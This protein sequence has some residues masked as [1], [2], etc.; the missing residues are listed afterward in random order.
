MESPR[1]IRA[2]I[3]HLADVI[4]SEGATSITVE[5]LRLMVETLKHIEATRE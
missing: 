5:Q 3:A 4:E 1:I 2:V